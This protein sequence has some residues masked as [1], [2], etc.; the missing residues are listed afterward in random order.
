[1]SEAYE[2][3]EKKMKTMMNNA[4]SKQRKTADTHFRYT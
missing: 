1:M 4:G 2:E 3:P